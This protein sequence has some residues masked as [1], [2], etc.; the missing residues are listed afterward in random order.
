MIDKAGHVLL[1]SHS[2]TEVLKNL[3]HQQEQAKVALV[4]VTQIRTG[5]PT[6]AFAA[7]AVKLQGIL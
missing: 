1:D 4:L 3:S 2:L 5:L 7:F 6:S